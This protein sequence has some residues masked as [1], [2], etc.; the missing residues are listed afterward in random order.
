MGIIEKIYSIDADILLFI[1]DNLRF[2]P[3]TTAMRF[4]T[5]LGNKGA[6]WL[7][8]GFIL[9]AFKKYRKV[10]IT[11]II[12]EIFGLIITNLMLKNAVHRIRPFY[13]IDGLTTLINYPKDWSFPSG[14]TTSSFAAALVIAYYMPKRYGI[15]AI[16]LAVL[17]A[18]S[19]LYVGVHYPS[20]V[21]GG[22]IC[23]AIAALLAVFFVEK[24]CNYTKKI[25]AAK[26]NEK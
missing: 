22:I 26:H 9:L 12:A 21:V 7:L 19:R 25:S 6:V 15:A 10:G 18:Y 23:G 4:I 3:I 2:A 1:Q 20:D 5:S 11:V 16:I 14:H 8:I 17:I 24:S 13:Y